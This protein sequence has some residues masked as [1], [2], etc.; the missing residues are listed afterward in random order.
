MSKKRTVVLSRR[1][2]CLIEN[3]ECQVMTQK[4]PDNE[5]PR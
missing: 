5:D 2:T 3:K 4:A 1:K